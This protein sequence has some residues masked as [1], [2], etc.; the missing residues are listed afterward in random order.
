MFA[1]MTIPKETIFYK[2]SFSF[3]FVNLKP[4]LP[5]RKLIIFY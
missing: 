5:G 2:T 1:E 4:L 3:A